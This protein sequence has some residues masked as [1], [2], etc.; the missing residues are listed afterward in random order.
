MAAAYGRDDKQHGATDI[1]DPDRH[2]CSGPSDS[3]A[4][5][6]QRMRIYACGRTHVLWARPCKLGPA[7][8]RLRRQDPQG[9]QPADV[10]VEQPTTFELVINLQTARNLWPAIPQALIASAAEAIE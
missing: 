3:A 1:S 8:R 5:Y 4:V 7:R 6:V 2:A 10:P 9:Q